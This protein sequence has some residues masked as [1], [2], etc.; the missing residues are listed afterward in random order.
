MK[1]HLNPK[2][3]VAFFGK[4]VLIIA[5]ILLTLP[6]HT[7]SDSCDECHL[8][9]S[10]VRESDGESVTDADAPG[11]LAGF[12]IMEFKG[13][14]RTSACRRCHGNLQES[15]KLPRSE[16]CL[17]CHTRGK[18]A[19]GDRRMVF[20]AEKN[21]WPLEKVSCADCHRAH[22][23]GN[24]AVKFL[25]TNVVSVC[26]GCHEKTFNLKETALKESALPDSGQ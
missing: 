17:K 25:T 15:N 18:A 10:L 1:A 26:S 5:A 24:P 9:R 12:H 20:H 11:T 19:Q 13:E 14:E 7:W 4:T 21:H 8:H 16:A 23:K 3:A 2:N 6:V 22:I